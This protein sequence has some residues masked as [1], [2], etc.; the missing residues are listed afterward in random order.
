AS[1]T[2]TASAARSHSDT[3]GS[4]AMSTAPSAT[5]AYDQK[6]PY[7]RVRQTSLASRRN[8]SSPSRSCQPERLEYD[9]EASESLLTWDTEHLVALAS[10]LPVQAPL[11]FAA[12]QR[13]PSAGA[14]TRPTTTS[15]P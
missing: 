14:D 2:M 7:A 3:S 10:A 1:V 6:S 13:L 9:I 5:S 11:P 12:H 4:A 8:G 15:S